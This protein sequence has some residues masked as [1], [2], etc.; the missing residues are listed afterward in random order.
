[1]ASSAD[2]DADLP[3]EPDRTLVVRQ[4]AASRLGVLHDG[5]PARAL[6][7]VIG[8]VRPEGQIA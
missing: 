8:R 3:V 1:M 2:R 6:D 5:R 7:R 4:R